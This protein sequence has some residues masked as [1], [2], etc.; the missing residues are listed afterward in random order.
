M[1]P[2]QTCGTPLVITQDL[3]DTSYDHRRVVRHSLQPPQTCGEFHTT[4][5]DTLKFVEH[6]LRYV[7]TC[8]Q[9]LVTI[10][11]LWDNLIGCLGHPLQER[12]ICGTF[13]V[14]FLNL[15]DSMYDQ[16]RLVEYSLRPSSTCVSFIRTSSDLWDITYDIL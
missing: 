15:W 6:I 14:I 2:H 3:W 9:T 10:S 8:T 12:Q 13:H 7:W 1:R 5:Y 4:L 11:N 16:F